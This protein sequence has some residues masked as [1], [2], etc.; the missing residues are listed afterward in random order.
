[1]RAFSAG[2]SSSGVSTAWPAMRLA[3]ASTSATAGMR[4]ARSERAKEVI[5]YLANRRFVHRGRV[6]DP[7]QREM[8][9]VGL[10]RLHAEQRLLGQDIRHSAPDDKG[11]AIADGAPEIPQIA[12]LARHL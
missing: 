7:G 4:S 9:H 12:G 5:E 2:D 10:L 6:P 1:M 11:G 8:D 3:A